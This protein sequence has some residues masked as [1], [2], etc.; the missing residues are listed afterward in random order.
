MI[1]TFS[2]PITR[3]LLRNG[4]QQLEENAVVVQVLPATRKKVKAKV[5]LNVN[6][7]PAQTYLER[8]ERARARERE[9]TKD[10]V[11]SKAYP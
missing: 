11:I 1:K 9:S 2:L 5:C 10:Q 7:R 4:C 8:R 3:S 6:A